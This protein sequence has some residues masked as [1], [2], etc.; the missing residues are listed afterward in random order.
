[1]RVTHQ[2]F[3][4]FQLQYS[5]GKNASNDDGDDDDAVEMRGSISLGGVVAIN[6]V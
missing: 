6:N 5:I 3:I 4:V 2:F 1:M